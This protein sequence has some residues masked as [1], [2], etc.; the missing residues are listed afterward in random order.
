MSLRLAFV[1]FRHGHIYDL[2]RRAQA[3]PEIEV[4]ADTT[5]VPGGVDPAT[6]VVDIDVRDA[7]ARLDADDRAL[8]A[9]RYVAGFDS[10]EL[11]VATARSLRWKSRQA[12]SNSSPQYCR[13]LSVTPRRSL[14]RSS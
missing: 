5:R 1:G 2:Y 4:V 13:I 6:E 12:S 8:L 10:T 7:M 11:G 9:L 3:M 14:T